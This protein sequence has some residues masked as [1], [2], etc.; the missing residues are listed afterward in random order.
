[1]CLGILFLALFAEGFFRVIG[2]IPPFMGIDV[3]VMQEI[4]DNVKEEVLKVL[5]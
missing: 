4:I 5:S 3:D 2:M 1:M